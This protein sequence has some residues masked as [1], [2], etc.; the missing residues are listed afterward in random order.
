MIGIN[1]FDGYRNKIR[2]LE[3][4]KSQKVC[5]IESANFSKEKMIFDECQ[6]QI[7]QAKKSGSISLVNWLLFDQVEKVASEHF[8]TRRVKIS[9]K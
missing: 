8:T 2:G 5:L 9:N 1:I 6:N 4:C 3:F 7:L